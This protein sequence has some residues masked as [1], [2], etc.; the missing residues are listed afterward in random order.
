MHNNGFAVRLLT[1]PEGLDPDDFLKRFGKPGWD[2]LV[3]EQA[4][5]FW[6]YRL[7]KALR[8]QDTSVVTG[9][10]GCYAGV[11]ALLE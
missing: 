5:D 10:G 9:K 7:N 8:A 1:L 4:A 2:K 6:Q 11:K 3:Q